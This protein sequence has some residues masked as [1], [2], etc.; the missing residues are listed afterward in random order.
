MKN[1]LFHEFTFIGD[2]QKIITPDAYGVENK[3]TKSTT[4]FY[5]SNGTNATTKKQ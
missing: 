5:Q 2:E 4:K 1:H 3:E